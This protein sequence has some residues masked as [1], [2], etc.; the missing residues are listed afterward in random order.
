MFEPL[1]LLGLSKH[2]S[3]SKL[4]EN[5][6]LRFYKSELIMP[7]VFS[8]DSLL[9]VQNEVIGTSLAV[10][11]GNLSLQKFTISVHYS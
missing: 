5:G 7:F 11:D 1:V 2:L 8:I 10:N 3:L 4:K 9:I 6:N